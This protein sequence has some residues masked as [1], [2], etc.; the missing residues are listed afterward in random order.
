[1]RLRLIA[2]ATL[3]L[4]L[5]GTQTAWATSGTHFSP[6]ESDVRTNY[7]TQMG[8]VTVPQAFGYD[9][10]QNVLYTAQVTEGSGNKENGNLTL[11]KIDNATTTH[12]YGTCL[13]YNFGH[14]VALGVEPFAGSTASPKN[15]WIWIEV[16]APVAEPNHSAFGKKIARLVFVNGHSYTYDR[17]NNRII[18]R[19]A[20][21][22]QIDTTARIFDL[23]PG[24]D[25]ESVSLDPVNDR[26]VVRARISDSYQYRVFN[27]TDVVP[28]SIQATPYGNQVSVSPT[29]L[30]AANLRAP[31]AGEWVKGRSFQGY[32]M[33]GDWIYTIVGNAYDPTKEDLRDK[34]GTTITAFS[35][36]GTLQYSAK[37]PLNEFDFA[38]DQNSE[39]DFFEPEGL[40]IR[41]LSSGAV[42]LRWGLAVDGGK[43][44][45]LAIFEK[46]TLYP[47]T[48]S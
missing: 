28:S 10:S 12:R 19:N 4:V 39:K 27:R 36:D 32:A 3:S 15:A 22:E 31:A 16:A 20:A 6:S 41:Q 34:T 30:A 8:A 1:M 11:T 33:Y 17:A 26:L 35:T 23:A 48:H 40:A 29:N 14:G 13:L 25:Q 42:R 7:P 45:K 5:I 9:N 37:T 46:Q 43:Y 44:K 2:A 18:E 38:T 24:A 47:A 21:K